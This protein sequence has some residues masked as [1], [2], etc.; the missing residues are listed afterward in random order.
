MGEKIEVNLFK[1]IDK[2]KCLE[3]I[4]TGYDEESIIVTYENSEI[5]IPRK[6]ISIVKTKYNWD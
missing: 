6:N 2:E 3:G 1:P 4:L 5:T